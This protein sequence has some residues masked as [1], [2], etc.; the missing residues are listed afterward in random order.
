MKEEKRNLSVSRS[1]PYSRMPDDDAIPSQPLLAVAIGD[2]VLCS[3]RRSGS[4][5]RRSRTAR[6]QVM[7]DVCVRVVVDVYRDACKFFFLP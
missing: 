4:A 7:A 1:R 6:D 3:R 2:L 5:K